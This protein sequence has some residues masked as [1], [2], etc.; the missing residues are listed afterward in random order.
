MSNSWELNVQMQYKG[1]C[2]P[3]IAKVYCHWTYN[4]LGH[5]D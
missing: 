3:Q 2:E 1:F 4:H 5:V